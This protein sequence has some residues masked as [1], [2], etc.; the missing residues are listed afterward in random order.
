MYASTVF[1]FYTQCLAMVGPSESRA[2]MIDDA[3]SLLLHG[4]LFVHLKHEK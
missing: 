4:F 3:E 1:G 2:V